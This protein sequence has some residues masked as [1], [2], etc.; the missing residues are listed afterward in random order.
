ME[1]TH[2]NKVWVKDLPY[3]LAA[4]DCQDFMIKWKKKE[5]WWFDGE[6]EEEM[7]KR[8]W[9]GVSVKE[10]KWGAGDAATS[11]K[12]TLSQLIFVLLSFCKITK[13]SLLLSFSFFLFCSLQCHI[14]LVDS[15]V[16]MNFHAY[17]VDCIS[18]M[19]I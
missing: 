14:C 10:W 8:N 15:L 16:Q 18:F 19:Y 11:L 7:R 17:G 13:L 6:E 12:S 4:S 9:E 2:K 3:P 1:F 5:P